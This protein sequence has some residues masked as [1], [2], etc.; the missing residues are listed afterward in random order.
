MNSRQKLWD[1]PTRI[2]H[3]LI[4][5]L[6]TS[7]LF[8]ITG[9]DNSDVHQGT[10][11]LAVCLVLLRFIWGFRGSEPSRFRSFP[12]GLGK[13]S[14]FIKSHLPRRPSQDYL[15]HN[16]L[17]SWTYLLMWGII[18]CLG[19]SG[20]LLT[21]D[22]YWGDERLE[23]AHKALTKL[24]QGLILAHFFGLILDAIKHRRQTWLGM[25]DGKR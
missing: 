24:L 17:A 18:I 5:L 23:G 7:N 11:L 15:G 9:D 19:L 20:W 25:I 6:V 3:W 16:P 8:F 21:T 22:A 14:D 2:L 1:V 4:A 12:L 13:L 10:G